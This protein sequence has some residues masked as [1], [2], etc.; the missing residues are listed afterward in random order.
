MLNDFIRWEWIG[1]L[2]RSNIGVLCCSYF[3]NKLSSCLIL[4]R[5]K[6][7]VNIY[8]NVIKSLGMNFGSRMTLALVSVF[9][10]T[11]S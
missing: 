7:V 9:N 2:T 4:T 5:E 8:L 11:H 1:Y 6:S 10:S 3:D